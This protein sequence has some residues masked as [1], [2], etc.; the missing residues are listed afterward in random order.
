MH[1]LSGNFDFFESI[2]TSTLENFEVSF[3]GS[4]QDASLEVNSISSDYSGE[5]TTIY[6]RVENN[7]QCVNVLEVSLVVNPTPSF[8][9]SKQ[10]L[11][12]Y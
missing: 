12:L 7:N 3:Y 9:F 8:E 4:R 1:V 2:D 11:V 10:H 6:A 5:A